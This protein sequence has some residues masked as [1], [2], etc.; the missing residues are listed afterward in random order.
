MSEDLLFPDRAAFRAWLDANG[1]DAGGV[2]LVLGKDGGPTTLSAR[3]ALEEALCFGWIDGR[4]QRLGDT[5]Y[6]KY[7][8]RRTAT[9]RWSAT[10]R[11]LAQTLVDQGAMTPAGS[12][13]I[14][15]AKSAGTW[16]GPARVVVDEEAVQAFQLAV[17]PH[18][19][20]YTHL[21]AMSP[22]VQRTYTAYFLDARSDATRRTRLAKIVDRLD[23]NLRPM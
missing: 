7:F 1:A 9:S 2:W 5:T 10:N 18:E 4:M 17:Q 3:E 15:R 13:A 23:Q 21:L 11:A 14:A 8:A 20:A 6:R 22:S 12:A 19:P 16:D